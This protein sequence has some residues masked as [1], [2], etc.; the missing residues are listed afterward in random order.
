MKNV[1]ACEAVKYTNLLESGKKT[2]FRATQNR[3]GLLSAD[4]VRLEVVGTVP[5]IFFFPI[6]AFVHRSLT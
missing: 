5:E 6:F 4:S 1:L 2:P 3:G